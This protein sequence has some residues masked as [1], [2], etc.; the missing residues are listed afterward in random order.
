M[1]NVK[2]DNAGVWRFNVIPV[3]V[4]LLAIPVARSQAETPSEKNL[5]EF[6]QQNCSGCHGVDGA[7]VDAQGKKLRGKDFTVAAWQSGAKDKT[8][9]KAIMKGVFFGW[10]MPAYGDKLTEV[11]AQQM[12]DILRKSKKGQVIAIQAKGPDGGK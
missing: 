4:I 1:N 9:V 2:S 7:A 6:Y 12:V 8:L 11:E 10:A 3:L 5:H